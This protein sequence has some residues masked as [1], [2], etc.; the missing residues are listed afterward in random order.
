MILRENI[1]D[2]T[3]IHIHFCDSS[4]LEEFLKFCDLTGIRKAGLVSLPDPKRGTF[5]MPVLA[6][7]KRAPDRFIGF[8][9]LDHR[10]ERTERSGSLQVKN[11]A[12]SGFHGLKL[13]IGKPSVQKFFGIAMEDNYITGALK[14]AEDLDMPVLFHL[15]DPPV[16]WNPGGPLYENTN[17]SS[18]QDSFQNWIDRGR[19]I[20]SRFTGT[21]FIG[22]HLLFLAG[23]LPELD[24]ILM[25][26][27]N[28]MLDTAPGRWFYRILAGLKTKAAA[29]FTKHA[30]RILLGSDS[31]FFPENYTGW[32]FPGMDKNITNLERLCSFLSADPEKR[33]IDDPFPWE[34][35]PG[36]GEYDGTRLPCLEL[37]DETLNAIMVNNAD[38][39]F[40]GGNFKSRQL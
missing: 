38:I 30:G 7:V 24:T 27:L 32:E 36:E 1:N 14:T 16:F 22:A 21:T 18:V 5:N 19:N 20:F 25:E 4:R 33:G 10:Q 29:F 31:F 39:F 37:S 8:G 3:D 34:K 17:G 2:L 23:G 35:Y 15:A 40:K 6:A 12:A 13:W 26:H 11:L 9:C 28:L